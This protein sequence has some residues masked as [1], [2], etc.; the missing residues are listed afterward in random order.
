M[1]NEVTQDKTVTPV[2]VG[3][4]TTLVFSE[5]MPVGVA[6]LKGLGLYAPKPLQHGAL[7]YGITH[8]TCFKRKRRLRQQKSNIIPIYYVQ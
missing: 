2:C 7:P 8:P 6:A 4:V 3:C 1:S 5:A